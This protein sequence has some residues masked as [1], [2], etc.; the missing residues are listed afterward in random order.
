MEIFS[1]RDH[2]DKGCV[3]D[4]ALS[5]KFIV[6]LYKQRVYLLLRQQLLCRKLLRSVYIHLDSLQLKYLSG[7]HLAGMDSH[8]LTDC[9]GS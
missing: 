1:Y 8:L 7:H 2:A 5:H 6:Y 4:G 9:M 3:R